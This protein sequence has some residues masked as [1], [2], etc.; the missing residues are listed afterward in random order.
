[1][2]FACRRTKTAAVVTEALAPDEMEETVK[3]ANEGPVP[4]MLDESNK[5]DNDE[6]GSVLLRLVN[7]GYC[8]FQNRF[9]DMPICNKAIGANLFATVNEFMQ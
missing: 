5:R 9:L 3:N 2:P 4:L 1:M 7:P 6:W 8:L